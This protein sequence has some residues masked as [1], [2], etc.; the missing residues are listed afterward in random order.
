MHKKTKWIVVISGVI[1]TMG[2]ALS[3][4][5]P[6]QAE[7]A[8]SRCTYSSNRH[9]D[10]HVAHL[11]N[12]PSHEE[13]RILSELTCRANFFYHEAIAAGDGELGEGRVPAHTR[14]GIQP[15]YAILAHEI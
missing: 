6:V 9:F 1:V 13:Q 5:S 15:Y 10:K 4:W 11:N 14:M 2:L 7:V 8:I 3:Q 12:A